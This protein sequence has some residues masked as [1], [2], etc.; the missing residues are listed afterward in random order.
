MNLETSKDFKCARG[1]HSFSCHWIPVN[2][3]LKWLHDKKNPFDV[4]A[5]KTC[6][7]TSYETLGHFPREISRAAKFLLNK[8]AVVNSAVSSN[9]YNA[10]LWFKVD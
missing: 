9:N 3:T 6:T 4:F 1:Y 7:A 8:R 5:I 2:E 10:L